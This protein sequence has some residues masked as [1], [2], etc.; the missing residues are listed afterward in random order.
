MAFLLKQMDDWFTNFK[1][2][3]PAT[4]CCLYKTVVSL[5][6][7]TRGIGFLNQSIKAEQTAIIYLFVFPLTM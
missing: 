5:Q 2:F 3:I 4:F 6:Q 1:V 7:T